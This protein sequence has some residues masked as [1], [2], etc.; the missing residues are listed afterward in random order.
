MA[1]DRVIL[2]NYRGDVYEYPEIGQ[3][4][5]ADLPR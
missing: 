5:T 2:K 3:P 1:D 4:S